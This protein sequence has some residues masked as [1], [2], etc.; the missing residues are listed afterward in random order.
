MA[1]DVRRAHAESSE[2]WRQF[3]SEQHT[4]LA[5]AART[6]LRQGQTESVLAQALATLQ[7]STPSEDYWHAFAMRTVVK[8]AISRNLENPLSDKVV[9]IS[10]YESREELEAL[11]MAGL[12]WAERAVYFLRKVLRY[13]RR[14][15]ALLMRM[16][17]ANVDQLLMF[18]EKRIGR[19]EDARQLKLKRWGAKV[20]DFIASRPPTGYLNKTRAL[21]TEY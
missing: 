10:S 19:N 9:D 3:F 15:T 11:Q 12:P 13:S 18:A 16:S 8:A 4:V 21:T 17:D 7:G 2:R 6:L 1:N 14:D 20:P 5:F